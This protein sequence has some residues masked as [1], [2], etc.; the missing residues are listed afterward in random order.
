MI[1]CYLLLFILIGFLKNWKFMIKFFVVFFRVIEWFFIFVSFL[2]KMIFCEY[3]KILMKMKFYIC[4]L[5][6]VCVL[7]VYLIN[8]EIMVF[9]SIFKF[10]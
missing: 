5:L 6:Y 10:K 4:I 2:K 7:Y 8:Y 3:I 1:I 9:K